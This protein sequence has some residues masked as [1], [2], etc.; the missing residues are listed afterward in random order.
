MYYHFIAYH[1][2]VEILVPKVPAGVEIGGNLVENWCQIGEKRD[3][4]ALISASY[5]LGPPL[6]SAGRGEL[7]LIPHS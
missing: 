1:K 3:K 2:E 7:K 6:Q 5:F 4:P